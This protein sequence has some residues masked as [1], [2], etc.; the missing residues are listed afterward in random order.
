MNSHRPVGLYS[1][2]FADSIKL[3]LESFFFFETGS[4]YVPLASL[5]LTM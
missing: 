2:I 5:E 4:F 3:S 1:D